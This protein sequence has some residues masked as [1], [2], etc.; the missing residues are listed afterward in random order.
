MTCHHC[1]VDTPPSYGPRHLPEARA[2]WVRTRAERTAL[3]RELAT[4]RTLVGMAVTTGLATLASAVVDEWL[5]AV[6][7]LLALNVL[8]RD[9]ENRAAERLRRKQ[10]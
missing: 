1:R 4:V 3:R 10:A 6:V 9:I 8:F 7:F 2:R 5:A